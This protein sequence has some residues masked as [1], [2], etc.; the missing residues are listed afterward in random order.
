MKYFSTLG[1]LMTMLAC[2]SPTEIPVR[3]TRL[4]TL[5]NFYGGEAILKRYAGTNYGPGG[6]TLLDSTIDEIHLTWFNSLTLQQ[7]PSQVSINLPLREGRVSLVSRKW[8]IKSGIMT[9]ATL[10][11]VQNLRGAFKVT[12]RRHNTVDDTLRHLEYIYRD[13][14]NYRICFDQGER[15]AYL[16][17]GNRY[18][19]SY[20]ALQQMNP[21][22]YC[23]T[24]YR[25]RTREDDQ[26]QKEAEEAAKTD[27]A[28][29][30]GDSTM[31]ENVVSFVEFYT[32]YIGSKKI[33]IISLPFDQ[34]QP[35][36]GILT[37]DSPEGAFKNREHENGKVM[38][39]GLL[40][41]TTNYYGV[42]WRKKPYWEIAGGPHDFYNTFITTFSKDG[43]V[44]SNVLTFL[45]K[46][47]ENPTSCGIT[48]QTNGTINADLS[49]FSDKLMHL[50]CSG[51]GAGVFNEIERVKGQVNNDG[52]ITY[53]KEDRHRVK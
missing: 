50:D 28:R 51:E 15:K 48:T 26:A 10:K 3:I 53:Q 30:Y 12:Y 24:L 41:D 6:V 46:S 8:T 27:Q 43:K 14:I 44:L 1:W 13:T 17:D 52:A 4:D 47:E 34:S 19:S 37:N 31:I 18:S 21:R 16:T 22:V 32:N 9:G 38:L 39:V 42:V 25:P 45:D 33:G 7:R 11:D 2:S 40:P 5:F 29:E 35:V 23:I 49:F 20:E 36:D